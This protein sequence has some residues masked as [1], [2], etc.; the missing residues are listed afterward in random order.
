MRRVRAW[1]GFRP[2][3]LSS[4]GRSSWVAAP[5][6]AAC[7]GRQASHPRGL[8]APSQVS[9]RSN[10]AEIL[11]ELAPYARRRLRCHGFF[12]RTVKNASLRTDAHDGHGV[13]IRSR[14]ATSAGAAQPLR[15]SEFPLAATWHLKQWL[16]SSRADAVALRAD[17]CQRCWHRPRPGVVPLGNRNQRA[18]RVIN[19]QE[20]QVETVQHDDRLQGRDVA[21][22]LLP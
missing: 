17:A 6:A 13:V 21:R 4:L 1:M 11:D 15:L 7:R 10:H 12:V 2:A 18:V 5:N 9:G 22:I 14:M 8:G 19:V 20:I 16:R 3:G